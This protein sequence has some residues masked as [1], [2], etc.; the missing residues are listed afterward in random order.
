VRRSTTTG[1]NSRLRSE[2]ARFSRIGFDETSALA[3]VSVEFSELLSETVMFKLKTFLRATNF[4]LVSI[5][6]TQ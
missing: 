6:Q 2:T 3:E 4:Q 5:T 1:M